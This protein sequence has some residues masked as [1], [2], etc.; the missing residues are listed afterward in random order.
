MLSNNDYEK[1][2]LRIRTLRKE[3]HITQEDLAHMCGC[4]SNHLSAIENGDHRPSFDLMVNIAAALGETLDYFIAD[5]PHI[6]S[7]Y[8]INTRLAK[9]LDS[10]DP[11]ELLLVEHFIDEMISYKKHITTSI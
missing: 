2:G 7:Q 4:T 11:Y 6:N 8:F 1:I 3:R 5:T 9:K 10:C